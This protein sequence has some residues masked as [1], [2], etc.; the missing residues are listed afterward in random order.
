MEIPSERHW[1]I[2]PGALLGGPFPGSRSA[3]ELD[4][5]LETLL[6]VGIRTFVSLMEPGETN[7]QGDSFAPYDVPVAEL[8]TARGIAVE[9]HRFPIPDYGTVSVRS[10]QRILETVSASI[11]AG[12]PVYLHCWGGHGRTGT[13]AGCWLRDRGAS[14][15]GALEQITHLRSHSPYLRA[16]ESPQTDPQREVVRH[17]PTAP[18]S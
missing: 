11:D 16:M 2:E 13:V 17:W 1:W 6:D 8:A 5:R 9:F 14:P 4:R 15:D 10:Y 18:A 7:D 3:E 12:R